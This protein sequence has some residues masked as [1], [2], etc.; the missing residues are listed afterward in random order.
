MSRLP[1]CFYNYIMF[2][3]LEPSDRSFGISQFITLYLRSYVN[4]LLID[5]FS[6]HFLIKKLNHKINSFFV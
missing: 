3:K 4:K 1:K 6:V 2:A 5:K